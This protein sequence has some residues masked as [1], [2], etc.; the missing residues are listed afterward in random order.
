MLL[1][2]DSLFSPLLV[3]SPRGHPMWAVTT[4][5]YGFKCEFFGIDLPFGIVGFGTRKWLELLV[6]DPQGLGSGPCGQD[7]EQ[8]K[9]GQSPHTAPGG[10]PPAPS[11]LTCPVVSCPPSPLDSQLFGLERAVL[12]TV[13]GSAC[14]R[15]TESGRALGC[16][17]MTLA[18]A[19][20][21][22]VYKNSK[23]P[24]HFQ[25]VLCARPRVRFLLCRL[26]VL[27]R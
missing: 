25:C 18:S 6:K 7:G 8:G 11:P 14:I 13:S 15:Q 21:P 3:P 23:N 22:D 9:V 27:T 26:F 17:G 12:S 16:W 4:V 10:H 5:S 1:S 2:G 19:C 24:Q 20:R